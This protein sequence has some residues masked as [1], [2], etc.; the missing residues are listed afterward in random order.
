MAIPTAIVAVALTGLV[1]EA[2]PAHGVESV[3]RPWRSTVIAAPASITPPVDGA[4]AVVPPTTAVSDP[5]PVSTADPAAGEIIRTERN[6]TDATRPT[7][8]RGAV[9]ASGT[10]VIRTVILRPARSTGPLPVVVFAHGYDATPELY[11]PLLESWAH[12]GYLVVAPDSPGSAA[13]LAGMPTRDDLANQAEDLSF[14]LSAVLADPALGADPSRVAAAGHSDG[15]TA[16]ALLALDPAADPRLDAFLVLSGDTPG[17]VVR[18]EPATPHPTMVV[19][20]DRDEYG[21]LDAS[22]ALYENLGFDKTLI[23]A[24]GGDHLGIYTDDGVLAHA[25]R[26]AIVE[27]LDSSLTTGRATLAVDG[28]VLSTRAE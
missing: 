9:P 20:G 15:G 6:L 12:A 24:L 16:V 27:F 18:A 19:V 22:T 7:P 8:A 21:N 4:D 11:L 13:D 26:S 10:R 25:V 3:G 5:V 14:V 23:V 17:G 1:G 2:A 28:R